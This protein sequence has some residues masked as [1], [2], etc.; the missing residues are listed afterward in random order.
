[1]LSEKDYDHLKEKQRRRRLST[2]ALITYSLFAEL[3]V[4]EHPTGETIEVCRELKV[5]G[6]HLP[7]GVVNR[8]VPISTE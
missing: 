4:K 3:E 5:I 8:G 6:N 1:M 7:T 2:S